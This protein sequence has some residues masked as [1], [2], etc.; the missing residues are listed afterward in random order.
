VVNFP[1][2]LAELIVALMH[3][4]PYGDEWSIPDLRSNAGIRWL[5]VVRIV[6]FG[7]NDRY[8][9]LFTATRCYVHI[10]VLIEF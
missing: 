4:F 1:A 7:L 8:P 6:I 5:M 10:M 9:G 3:W 2:E